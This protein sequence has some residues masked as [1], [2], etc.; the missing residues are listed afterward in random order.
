M[1]TIPGIVYI[2]IGAGV[3]Y[4]SRYFQRGGVNLELFYWAG[5]LFITIGVFKVIFRFITKKGV[6]KKEKKIAQPAILE[7]LHIEETVTP[8]PQP[9]KQQ[10]KTD[11][12]KYSKYCPKC[13]LLYT[14]DSNFCS[15]CGSQLYIKP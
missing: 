2:I 9:K 6:S 1:A 8:P 11:Y 15:K 13:M 3:S 7:P 14:Q 10:K 5:I 12:S 4:I